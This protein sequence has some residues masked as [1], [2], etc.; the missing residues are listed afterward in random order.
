MAIPWRELS[1]TPIQ[2]LLAKYGEDEL[3]ESERLLAQYGD[4]GVYEQKVDNDPAK[5]SF[6]DPELYMRAAKNIPQSFSKTV[7]DIAGIPAGL[8][9]MYDMGPLAVAEGI[10]SGIQDR[11][12][13]TDKIKRTLVEDPLGIALDV[14][15][16]MSLLGKAAKASKIGK[17]ATAGK[18]LEEASPTR[19]LPK[20]ARTPLTVAEEIVPHGVSA[21]SGVDIG[22]LRGGWE[23]A[24]RG[25][26]TQRTAMQEQIMNL[27]PA[28][29]ADVAKDTLVGFKKGTSAQWKDRRMAGGW[30]NIQVSPNEISSRILAPMQTLLNDLN[31]K[32]AN[33]LRNEGKGALLK[34]AVRDVMELSTK[35]SLTVEKIREVRR[36][37]DVLE[38]RAGKF[39]FQNSGRAIRQMREILDDFVARKSPELKA[40]D[41]WYS[42]KSKIA[43]DFEN[44]TKGVLPDERRASLAKMLDEKNPNALNDLRAIEQETGIPLLAIAAGSAMSTTA[45]IGLAGQSAFMRALRALAPV[46]IG[47]AAGGPLG[48]AALGYAGTKVASPQAVGKLISSLG[49]V[50]NK[51]PLR[52]LHEG[53]KRQIAM[54]STQQILEGLLYSGIQTSRNNP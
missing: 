20:L 35:P 15:P 1:T 9:S 53:Y 14:A 13:S 47:Y 41:A 38:T 40:T 8:K 23:T 52:K 3:N 42:G 30:E 22:Q 18:L 4:V 29:G 17:V 11:Y 34:L 45:P 51:T 2:Q 32:D 25:T 5:L 37:L 39:Q 26:P 36:G 49:N 43:K 44:A 28:K 10:V 24:M 12:G 7:G 6:L 46:G 33:A 50:Y 21:Y 16:G 31:T 19:M 54:P 27:A 48:G